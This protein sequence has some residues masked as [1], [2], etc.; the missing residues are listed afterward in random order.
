MPKNTAKGGG[1]VTIN[2]VHVF[3]EGGKITKGPAKFIGSSVNDLPSGKSAE[4]KKAALKAKY[5]TTKKSVVESE[6]AEEAKKTEKPMTM[7]DYLKQQ[8]K[9][10]GRTEPVKRGVSARKSTENAGEA[11]KAD[12]VKAEAKKIESRLDKIEGGNVTSDS[13]QSALNRTSNGVT[14]G[15]YTTLKNAYGESVELSSSRFGVEATVH[16]S[17]GTSSTVYAPTFETQ[18]KG[19]GGKT[20]TVSEVD[21]EGLS[22]MINDNRFHSNSPSRVKTGQYDRGL[23]TYD[24]ETSRD[25]GTYKSPKASTTSAKSTAKSTAKSAPTS[26]GKYANKSAKD[27][28]IERKTEAYKRGGYSASE[29]KELAKYVVNEEIK[30]SGNKSAYSKKS[31]SSKETLSLVH[32]MERSGLTDVYGRPSTKTPV[33]NTYGTTDRISRT[34]GKVSRAGTSVKTASATPAA[35]ANFNNAVSNAR[36]GT[37]SKNEKAMQKKYGKAFGMGNW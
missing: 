27:I 20:K 29:A 11:K 24:Y 15:G 17:N 25:A 3:I 2:G 30:L 16:H 14:V 10:T 12:K 13:I 19:R 28:L 31:L 26:S 21:Y 4:D 9:L 34:A 32:S 36:K 23:S 33:Q 8:N 5:G 1:W 7:G 37:G 18:V 35:Q 22:N 6:K